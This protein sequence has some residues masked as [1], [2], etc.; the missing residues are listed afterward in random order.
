[1]PDSARS[2]AVRTLVTAEGTVEVSLQDVPVGEPGPDEVVVR[3]EGAA[4]NPSDLGVLF[5]GAD[6][7]RAETV[8][9]DGRPALVA[10]LSE[11]A[12]RAVAGRAG[13]PLT[14]G[15]EGAGTVIAAGSSEAAQALMGKVVG[16]VGGAMY[17][18]LRRI[19]LRACQPFPEGTSAADGAGWFINP[20]TASAM[21]ATMRA[22]GHSAI[23]HT[24]AG[25]SLGHMLLRLCL[26]DGVGLVNV[27]R[28]AEPAAELREAGAT[29]VCD[30]SSRRFSEELT[31]AVAATGATLGFDAL[32][33]GE[34]ID[35]ILDA[36]ERAQ[37]RGRPFDRYGSTT[38]KQVYVYGG[39]ERSPTTLR[40]TYGMS[41]GVGGWLLYRSLQR[42]GG[43][44]AAEMQARVA[45]ELTTTFAT[46]FTDSIGLS[47]VV[48][49]D[50]VRTYGA[51][52]TGGKHLVDPRLS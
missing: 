18:E 42:L 23:V 31:D 2:L 29:H 44:A 28:R 3:V 14:A 16:M 7:Q 50:V 22:E 21:L 4:I 51:A 49:P 34:L 37:M 20:M 43:E 35:Q 47:A 36:M 15:N 27:V 38:H 9:R 39:L 11:G 8:Q 6:L 48:D 12:A 45:A 41:W 17:T 52:S 32:G 5:A 19:D 30:S 46:S 13:Q 24:A 1:M 25:S 26:A 33:G 40:R 10:P